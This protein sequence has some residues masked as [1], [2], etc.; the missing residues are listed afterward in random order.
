MLLREYTCAILE[1]PTAPVKGSRPLS[2]G[3]AVGSP[4]ANGTPA[5]ISP[6]RDEA[7]SR[8]ACAD[9]AITPASRAGGPGPPATGGGRHRRAPVCYRRYWRPGWR[10]PPRSRPASGD[11]AVGVA[12]QR[13]PFASRKVASALQVVLWDVGAPLLEDEGSPTGGGSTPMPTG[14]G[15]HK[16]GWSRSRSGLTEGLS[17]YNV[18]RN[19]VASVATTGLYDY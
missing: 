5:R 15:D 9:P 4:D 17:P 2:A 16:V 10:P 18:K 11:P 6:I 14:W 8:S 3:S 7:A 1:T 13:L 19:A 12:L